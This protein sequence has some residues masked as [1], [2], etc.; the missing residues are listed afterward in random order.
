[1]HVKLRA[2]DRQSMASFGIPKPKEKGKKKEEER[3]T[4]LAVAAL[5]TRVR[6]DQN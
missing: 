1:M 2:P 3:K 5:H 6:S 4:V